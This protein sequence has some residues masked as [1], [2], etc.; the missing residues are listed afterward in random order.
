MNGFFITATDT[1]VGK[2]LVAGGIASA[3]RNRGIDIGVYK[4]LQSGH[5]ANDEKGDAARLKRLSEI[6][7]GI[8]DICPY[9]FSEPLAPALAIA[10]QGQAIATAD[11]VAHAQKLANRHTYLIVEGAGGLAV[12][13]ASDGLVVDFAK[14]LR[15]PL[16]IVARPNLGT[17]N[18]SVLTIEYARSHGLSV[19][20]VVISGFQKETDDLSQETNAEMIAN[21]GKV[22]I[23]GVLP[24][25]GDDP[26]PQIVR[27]AVEKHVAIDHIFQMVSVLHH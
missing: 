22:P 13:Y 15:L 23:L 18:H 17:V 25:L 20:G 14:E 8:A 27:E 5:L 2:T 7:D 12:P 6:E 16:L 19:L 1:D 24:W 9:S 4:P 11:L 3:F 21:L 26:P 10:R